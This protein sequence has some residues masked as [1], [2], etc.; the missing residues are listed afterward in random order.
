ME[1]WKIADEAGWGGV[2]GCSVLH[3]LSLRWLLDIQVEVQIMQVDENHK[4][5][6]GI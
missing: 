3:M 2:I 5:G 1:M 6:D 4:Q